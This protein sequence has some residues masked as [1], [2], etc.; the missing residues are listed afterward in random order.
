LGALVIQSVE[1][2]MGLMGWASG[3]KFVVNGLVLLAAVLVDAFSRRSR[4][5]SGIA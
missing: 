4:A 1:N 2:G 5:S 3:E